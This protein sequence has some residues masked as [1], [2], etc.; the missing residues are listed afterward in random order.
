MPTTITLPQLP[1]G[2]CAESAR[3]PGNVTVITRNLLVSADGE[4]FAVLLEEMSRIWLRRLPRPP[5]ESSIDHILLV[6]HRDRRMDAYVNELSIRLG[7]RAKGAVNAG[8]PVFFESIA[9]TLSLEFEGVRIPPDA[10]YLVLL[11]QGWRRGVLYDFSP[12]GT[13]AQMRAGSVERELAAL[14]TYLGF[15][16]RL[17]LTDQDWEALLASGWFPF[18][19]LGEA[20][21]RRLVHH[22]RACWD[23]D[24]LLPELLADVRA[25]IPAIRDLAQQQ[26]LFEGHKLI[27]D[28]A[29]ERF[30]AEDYVSATG[31]LYPRIEGL[32]RS[33]QKLIDPGKPSADALARSVAADPTETRHPHS[34]LLPHRFE[35]YLRR[36]Y[37][38]HFSNEAPEGVGRHTV[39]HGVAPE[40]D[41]G[42]KSAMLALLTMDQLAFMLRAP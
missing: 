41:F 32:L 21:I 35:E 38:A 2:F 12:L 34:L 42:P 15:H 30:E 33:W 8:A 10:G 37:F 7:V 11:S 40:D 29:I 9:D 24:E 16:A 23:L 20:R 3:G 25:S 6:F 17:S 39:G 27:L 18:I 5:R 36:V 19:R 4:E 14:W 31:L 26:P 22:A 13:E 1:V 28:R